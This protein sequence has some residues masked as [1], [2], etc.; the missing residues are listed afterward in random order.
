[1]S[2]DLTSQAEHAVALAKA[3][4]ADEVAA[5]ISQNRDVTFEYRD[6]AL[7][8]VKDTTSQGLAVRI[9]AA[10]RYSS[11]QTT[12]LNPD[13]LKSFVTEAV[14]ITKALEP[15]EYRKITPEELFRNRPDVDLDLVDPAIVNISRNQR[16]EWCEAIDAVATDHEKVISAT[17]GIYDGSSQSASVSSIGFSG[18][19]RS[20]YC[21]YGSEITLM[22]Q[23][24]KRA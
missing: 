7:E 16:L 19:Q 3:A 6:G 18:T 5:S 14:A 11:H 15:D 1:M 22:D 20:T 17:C 23:G 21:W 12:D 10:D 13:R 24:D 8:K 9:Y 2:V 4:G